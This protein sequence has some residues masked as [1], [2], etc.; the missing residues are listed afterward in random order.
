MKQHSLT[1]TDNNA[2]QTTN[3][4]SRHSEHELIQSTN[5]SEKWHFIYG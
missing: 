2:L 4:N 3:R 1:L 5:E